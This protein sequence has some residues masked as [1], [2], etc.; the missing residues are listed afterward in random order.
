MKVQEKMKKQADR[1]RK[2]AEVQKIGDRIMLSIKNLVF[3][4]KLA[5]KLVNQYLGP[6][7]IKKVI[8]TNAVKL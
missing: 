1:G 4:E 2:E 7:T 5:K 3:K 8:S 6:Y